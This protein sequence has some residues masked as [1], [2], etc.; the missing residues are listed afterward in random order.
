MG[1][2]ICKCSQ[3]KLK[4]N[5]QFSDTNMQWHLQHHIKFEGNCKGI[6]LIW[7]NHG[8]RSVKKQLRWA[9]HLQLKWT[10]SLHPLPIGLTGSVSTGRAGRFWNPNQELDWTGQDW[11]WG[12]A[13]PDSAP[14]R[15]LGGPLGQEALKSPKRELWDGISYAGV[16]TQATSP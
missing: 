8:T 14:W 12:L 9:N 11:N 16:P 1:E 10:L 13:G 3:A 15:G 7:Q 4:N 6:Q 2:L 5:S